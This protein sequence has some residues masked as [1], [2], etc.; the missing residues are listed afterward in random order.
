MRLVMHGD[1]VAAAR[2]LL[3]LP[4]Q[5]RDRACRRM[6]VEAHAAH[7]YAKR[8]GRSHFLWGDGSLM[9]AAGGHPMRPEPGF[10]NLD[11][12]LCFEQVLRA[13]IDWRL[14]RKRN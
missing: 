14:S 1:V 5:A 9:S 6:I 3:A 10:S 2:V 4:P 11:Y 8:F 13:L 7:L 12:C